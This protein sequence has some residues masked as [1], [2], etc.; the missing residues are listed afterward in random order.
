MKFLNN[1]YD[2]VNKYYNFLKKFLDFLVFIILIMNTLIQL[3]TLYID[4][5]TRL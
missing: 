5:R 1:L 2:L 3:F 4:T